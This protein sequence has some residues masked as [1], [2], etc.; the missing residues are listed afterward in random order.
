MLTK[1]QTCKKAQ[2]LQNNQIVYSKKW[3][4]LD[5]QILEYFSDYYIHELYWMLLHMLDVTILLCGKCYSY[6]ILGETE[7]E[8]DKYCLGSLVYCVLVLGSNPGL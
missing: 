6:F 4:V 7:C 2:H 1:K 5:S 3:I 8:Q